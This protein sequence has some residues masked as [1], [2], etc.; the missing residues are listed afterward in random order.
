MASPECARAI[1]RWPAGIAAAVAACLCFGC[2][3]PATM[4]PF[5]QGRGERLTQLLSF[6]TRL[7]QSA[8]ARR[9]AHYR[10]PRLEQY[11]ERMV[12]GLMREEA[13]PG[14]VPRVVLISDTGQNA[15]SFPDGAIYIHTG[16]LAQIESEAELALLLAHELAHITRR[17][18]LRALA[19]SPAGTGETVFDRALSDSLSWFHELTRPKEVADPSQEPALELARLRRT[20]EG[21][22]DTVGLDMVVKANYDPHEA[23]EI[24]EHLKEDNG[25]RAGQARAA[26]LLQVLGPAAPA[27]GR[28]TDRAAFGRHLQHLLLEQGWLE[29]RH[30]RS[31]KALQCAR[32]V[33]R[34]TPAH[35]RGHFLTGEILRQRNEAEDGPQALAH[36]FQAI[37]AD[38]SLPEPHKAIGLIHLKQGQA[39]LARGFFEKALALAPHAPDSDYIRNYLTQCIITIEGENS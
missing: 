35:A 1:M 38:P 25:G 29:L 7:Q 20:L 31:E 8:I 15:Y 28:L 12:G 32:R 14:V 9:S 37:A 10:E 4:V 6:E 27:A 5:S 11:L 34:V 24:F 33:L 13:A 36:Y 16:L 22:A 21:E 39:R 17:H 26:V 30:G 23:L 2:T 3:G 19:A 18:A